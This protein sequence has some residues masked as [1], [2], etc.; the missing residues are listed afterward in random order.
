MASITIT[1]DDADLPRVV[2]GLC[3]QIGAVVNA[4]NAKQALTQI[5]SNAIIQAESAAQ[6]A[7]LEAQLADPPTIVPPPITVS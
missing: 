4:D 1:C 2:T 5:I 7:A 6:H 3:F